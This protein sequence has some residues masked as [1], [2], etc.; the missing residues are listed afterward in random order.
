MSPD[1]PES[2]LGLKKMNIFVGANNSG[3]SRFMR[4]IFASDRERCIF[5]ENHAKQLQRI[6]EDLFPKFQDL[7][8][9]KDL[10]SII[11]IAGG[12]YA[13]S[14]NS[15]LKTINIGT[16]AKNSRIGDVYDQDVALGISNALLSSGIGGQIERVNI[17]SDFLYIPM[18]RGVRNV[19]PVDN[20]NS[21]APLVQ[22]LRTISHD[23][24]CDIYTIRTEYDYKTNKSESIFSGLTIYETIKDM[25]LGSL[26]DRKK[27][28]EFE[29]F[30][31]KTFF[32]NKPIALIPDSKS[33]SLKINIQ[34]GDDRK[35][36]DV[37][38]GIQSIIIATLPV[39]MNG[40]DKKMTLFIEEPEM[41]MHPGA[42]RVLIETYLKHFPNLQI[43]LTTH[44]NHFLDI[45]YDYPDDVAIYSFEENDNGGKKEIKN[46]TEHKKILDILGVRNSSVFLANCVIW[47][48]GVT[49]RML[50]RE[51]LKM[52]KD[53]NYKEDYH[54]TFAEYG[55][56]NGSNF[57]FGENEDAEYTQV[58]VDG[59]SGNNFIISDNDN[60][61]NPEDIKYKNREGMKKI[62]GEE[63]F[64]DQHVEIENL[65]PYRIWLPV[66]EKIVTRSIGLKMK[67]GYET[68]EKEFNEGIMKN[69]INKVLFESIIDKQEDKDLKYFNTTSIECLGKGK[70]EIMEFVLKEIEK[71]REEDS[72]V[73]DDFPN[74]IQLLLNQIQSFVRQNNRV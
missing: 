17:E 13:S 10:I 72:L 68:K 70:K 8:T 74:T 44:S 58:R 29:E 34:E 15:F 56:S 69:K 38:D 21:G 2:V 53:F 63:N 64:F 33:D 14:Y 19:Y 7:Y 1:D 59:I 16:R 66:V 49:D 28:K 50:I 41:T 26:S 31:G 24:Q 12:D 62:V 5:Y 48:E 18:L 9:M 32:S 45:I 43:F 65:I 71:Q 46:V 67:E 36:H 42:Q 57:Y 6:Y 51:L 54:Y 40:V 25:L 23:K 37:G 47:T 11:N 30:L 4:D 20:S 60:Q 61:K 39:F 73:V 27:I 55:G 22:N 3:K 35:I 52:S